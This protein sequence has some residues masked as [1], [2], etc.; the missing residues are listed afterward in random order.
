M[1][2]FSFY[3]KYT[4]EVRWFPPPPPR[5][6]SYSYSGSEDEEE[7]E[8]PEVIDV[9]KDPNEKKQKDM[10]SFVV[11]RPKLDSYAKELGGVSDSEEEAEDEAMEP[12]ELTSAQ[13]TFT[14]MKPEKLLMYPTPSQVGMD[15]RIR[16]LLQRCEDL[17]INVVD[18]VTSKKLTRSM[19]KMALRDYF[20]EVVHEGDD[21]AYLRSDCFVGEFQDIGRDRAESALSKRKR[22]VAEKAKGKKKE[23][24]ERSRTAPM[25]TATALASHGHRGLFN[26][27]EGLKCRC[28]NSNLEGKSQ[29]I[30]ERHLKGKKHKAWMEKREREAQDQARLIEFTASQG[31]DEA[32]RLELEG[33]RISKLSDSDK[34]FCEETVLEFLRGGIPLN[35]LDGPL[36]RFLMKISHQTLSNRREL[37]SECIPKLMKKEVERQRME[38]RDVKL[39]YIHDATPR[40]GDLYA[41]VARVIDMCP[42]KR[43]AKAVHKLI[44]VSTMKGSMNA[45][46]LSAEI[47][48]ALA[49]RV[50]GQ[51]MLTIYGA[52][53]RLVR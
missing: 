24:G 50:E 19:L 12:M 17:G 33:T 35:K 25:G 9:N 49:N 43:T 29:W 26:S 21:M 40:Q 31:K 52:N 5:D 10:G 30:I 18:Q 14:D 3:H 37:A 4:F 15:G 32:E 38:C 2:I 20:V 23:T 47:S 48:K 11:G 42:K 1:G 13:R 45:D 27:C 7:D 16:S 51:R 46:S 44:H 41:V 34:A 39:S 36:R 28:N 6:D 22:E 53:G 8:E